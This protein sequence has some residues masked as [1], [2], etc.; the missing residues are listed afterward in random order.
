MSLAFLSPKE[1]NHAH[2]HLGPDGSCSICG[3]QEKRAPIRL[4]QTLWGLLFVVNA[5]V[6]DWVLAKSTIE[7]AKAQDFDKGSM[8]AGFSA[9]IGAIL[10]GYPIVWKALQDLRR[11]I[12]S[13]NELVGLAVLA[14]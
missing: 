5:Y 2:D 12:L 6:V 7:T 3:Q 10:L 9:M 4:W 13:I 11:G 8:V 1:A 14:S